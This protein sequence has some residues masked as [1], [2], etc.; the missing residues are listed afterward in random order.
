M[1][2]TTLSD[3]KALIEEV[4]REVADVVACSVDL[5]KGKAVIKHEPTLNLR[6]LK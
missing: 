3:C 4:C 6:L 2:I 5:R 1:A